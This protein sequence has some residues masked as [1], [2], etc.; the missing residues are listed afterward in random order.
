MKVTAIYMKANANPFRVRPGDYK[1]VIGF[2]PATLSCELIAS[3]A[4]EATPNGYVFVGIERTE[5]KA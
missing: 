3:Y 4:R 1:R 2:L 5:Y